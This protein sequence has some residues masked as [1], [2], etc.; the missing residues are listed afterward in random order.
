MRTSIDVYIQGELYGVH[1]RIIT[2]GNRA[3]FEIL[4]TNRKIDVT[5]EIYEFS[6]KLWKKIKK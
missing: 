1:Y 3:I 2:K 4:A 6:E 5:D